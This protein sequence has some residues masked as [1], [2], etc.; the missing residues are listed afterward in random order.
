MLSVCELVNYYTK[1]EAGACLICGTE[2][3]NVM[4]FLLYQH[5]ECNV[6]AFGSERCFTV[7]ERA[8]C[9]SVRFASVEN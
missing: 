7:T 5:C 6:A 9:G 4:L 3:Q 1:E 8:V 2:A